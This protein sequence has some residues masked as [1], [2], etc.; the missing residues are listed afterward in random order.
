MFL[1]LKA[2]VLQFLTTDN[3]SVLEAFW[4][5]ILYHL[6]SQSVFCSH[7]WVYF[8][9][10]IWQ[11]YGFCKIIWQFYSFFT[12]PTCPPQESFDIGI[13]KKLQYWAKKFLVRKRVI[14]FNSVG[15]GAMYIIDLMEY[16]PSESPE[17]TNLNTYATAKLTCAPPPLPSQ[18]H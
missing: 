1:S 14:L 10:K 11:F 2:T 6:I 9:G 5:D 13:V 12:P 16:C 17:V 4:G 18:H 15:E 3:G 7:F 8:G